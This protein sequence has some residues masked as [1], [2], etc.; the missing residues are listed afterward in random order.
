[1]KQQKGEI[2]IYVTCLAAYNNGYPHGAWIDAEQDAWEIYADIRQMLAVSPVE[3][4]EEWAIHDHEGFEGASVSEYMGIEQVAE[5]AAFI[6][7][8]GEIGAKLVEY[9]GGLTEARQAI[10]DNYAGQYSSLADFAEELT[11]ETTP[12]PESL[13]YYIDYE[14]MARDLE[15]SDVFVIETG[16]EQV[17]VFWSH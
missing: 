5:L 14:R 15:I 11:G 7:E 4:A 6:A 3:N 12:I 2:K 17:H 8:H 16:F 13:R 10:E 1:M 9:F